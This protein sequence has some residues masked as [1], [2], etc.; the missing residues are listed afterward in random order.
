[1]VR[2]ADM[3][4]AVS[5]ETCVELQKNHVMTTAR[6]AKDLTAEQYVRDTN[7]LLATSWQNRRMFAIPAMTDGIVSRTG[8]SIP[9]SMRMQRPVGDDPK[10]GREYN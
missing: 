8:L 1:M 10:A 5:K 7:P 4:M 9:P 6:N 2:I 3:L